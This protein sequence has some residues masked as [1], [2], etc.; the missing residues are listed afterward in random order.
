VDISHT[1]KKYR[2]PSI[3]ST[4]AQKVNK[5][6]GPSEDAP[7]PTWDGEESNLLGGWGYIG[8]KGD[9][10]GKKEI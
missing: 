2:I 4:E 5:P 8:G 1:Q 6:K 9:M 7:I 3:Q 10:E